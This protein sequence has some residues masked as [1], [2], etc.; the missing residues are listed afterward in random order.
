MTDKEARDLLVE[1]MTKYIEN[2]TR[3]IVQYGSDK[4]FDGWFSRQCGLA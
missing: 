3:W 1:I 2:R 4:G